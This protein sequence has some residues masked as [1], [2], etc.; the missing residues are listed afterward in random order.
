MTGFN[1]SQLS[2]LY[3]LFGLH[4]FVHAHH[5][6]VLLI[7]SNN[8][9]A[10]TGA[11]KCY[12]IDPEELLLYSLTRIKIGM[13]QEAIID[14]Y[15]G[16]DYNRWSYGHCWLMLYLNMRYASIIGHEGILRFLH[17]FG[18]FRDAIEVYCQKDWLYFDHQG[19]ATLIPGL[20][21]LPF[22]I[23]GFIDNTIDP[24]LVPF[25]GPAGNYKGAPRQ[26]QYILA[27][28]YIYTGYKKL[29]GHKM[30]MVFFPNG[31][32]T[33]FDPVSARQ[34][35]RGTLAMSGLDRFLVLIPAHL[36][37]HLQCMV[38]GDSIFRGN[39]QMITLY[40]R[41]LPPDVLTSSELKC[42]ASLQ[43]AQMPIE[44]KYGLQSC[45]QRLCDTRRG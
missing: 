7:G 33:C 16:G 6:T 22:N 23:C 24:I 29:H 42:N 43:A 19:N 39:L 10:V 28:E 12:R 11:E 27:H 4:D 38:F 35:D 36:A 15:F 45:V 17:L 18:E 44:K 31:I 20:T 34:N 41:A 40:Y 3:Q 13:T 21:E 30:E 2:K 14:H 8:F 25:S 1:I 26:L 37:P 32:S 5:K 9:D